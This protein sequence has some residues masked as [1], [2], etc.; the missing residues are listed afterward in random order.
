MIAIRLVQPH[1]M[2]TLY[3]SPNGLG[4]RGTARAKA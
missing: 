4:L 3:W 2:N 1:K